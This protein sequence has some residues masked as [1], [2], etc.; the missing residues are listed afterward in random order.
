MQKFWFPLHKPISQAQSLRAYTSKCS[1]QTSKVKI[2]KC[3]LLWLNNLISHFLPYRC[4]S[5]SILLPLQLL[6]LVSTLNLVHYLST[7]YLLMIRIDFLTSH[8]CNLHTTT[9]LH[10]PTT[11][12]T[13]TTENNDTHRRPPWFVLLC[14]LYSFLFSFARA[15]KSHKV[16]PY[17]TSYITDSDPIICVTSFLSR[18]KVVLFYLFIHIHIAVLFYTSFFFSNSLLILPS[19]IIFRVLM[20]SV[21]MK[22]K[23]TTRLFYY[24]L[25]YVCTRVLFNRNPPPTTVHTHSLCFYRTNFTIVLVPIYN[26]L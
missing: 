20:L 19:Q 8:Y 26:H 4:F 3:I 11:T 5:S 6:N 9:C 22:T 18:R 12:T 24:V 17:F 10:Q 25:L 15:F 13:K 21:K 2:L 1:K 14:L 7:C 23:N 16:N